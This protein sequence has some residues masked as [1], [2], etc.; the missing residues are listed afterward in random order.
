[1]SRLLIHRNYCVIFIHLYFKLYYFIGTLKIIGIL[2]GCKSESRLESRLMSSQATNIDMASNGS[3]DESE[4]EENT[5][6]NLIAK[7]KSGNDSET[8]SGL[9][10]NLT[11][12]E[13]FCIC[14]L[15]S[16][17]LLLIRQ[18]SD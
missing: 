18:Q 14:L 15:V 6:L 8:N 10:S 17:V 3:D 16:S 13:K 11:T 5:I 2:F 7:H 1:M 12:T 9:I 4:F